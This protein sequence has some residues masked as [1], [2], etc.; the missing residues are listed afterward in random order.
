M[1]PSSLIRAIGLDRLAARLG[2]GL[3]YVWV[4]TT[5]L[6]PEGPALDRQ[7]PVFYV[8]ETRSLSNLLVLAREARRRGLPPPLAPLRLGGR[9]LPWAVLGLKARQ[10]LFGRPPRVSYI[11]A[12]AALLEAVERDP[13]LEVQL[14]PVSVFW[15]R[16]P[17]RKAS[18]L[19]LLFPDDWPLAGRLRKFLLIL[20][21][22][23]N[24][25]VEFSP[26]LRLRRYREEIEPGEHAVRKLA[27]VLGVHFRL[28]RQAVLGPELPGRRAVIEVLVNASNVRRAIRE[29][30][31]DSEFSEAQLTV[32]ARRYAEEIA[33]GFSYPL[34]LVLR[35]ALH[36]VWH[37]L[38]DGIALNHFDSVREALP[39]NQ[40]IYVPCHRSHIDY[41]LILYLLYSQGLALP[42]V[43]AGINLNA[44]GIGFFVR[45]G[46]AFF[47]RRTFKGN[48]L[49]ATVLD[50]YMSLHLARGV[51]LKYFIEGG[52]SRSGYLLTPKMGLLDMTV[53][54]FFRYPY[55]PVVFVPI[56][57]GYER[58]VE[59]ES[60]LAELRG[61]KKRRESL[62]GLIRSLGFLRRYH[63]KVYLNVGEPLDLA[64]LLAA[65]RR[66]WR[67]ETRD[68][69]DRP[70][71]L[72]PLVERLARE[73][74]T[75]VNEA[76]A[77][78]PMNLLALV[79]LGAPRCAMA[80]PALLAQLDL[81]RRLL[82]R[83]P[84]HPRT[85][86]TEMD[87]R[88]IL[89][90]A[91][92]LVDLHVRQDELGRIVYLE[93]RAGVLVS[94]FR[95]NS[96]HLLALPALL[97]R[98]FRHVP[99]G[100]DTAQLVAWL[101]LLY[102]G[103]RDELFLHWDEA[104]LPAEVPRQLAGLADLGLLLQRDGRWY[105]APGEAGLRLALLGRNVATT[106]ERLAVVAL[107]LLGAAPGE[108]DETTLL[109]RYRRF[110][111]R[112]ELLHELSLAGADERIP[113]PQLL[114]SLV[115][116]GWLW[117]D[118]DGRLG[119]EPA[120]LHA[121][122]GLERLL[123]WVLRGELVAAPASGLTVGAE[124]GLVS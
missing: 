29:E 16:S 92:R 66:D 50:E 117:R 45:R 22:G 8:L 96:L 99:D 42:R 48:R 97:A 110:R 73:I 108:L 34:I 18:G 113:L 56:Y 13:A 68:L 14:Q 25:W 10:R 115:N 76:A 112:V 65:H 7:Q 111:T 83:L 90:H 61:E 15:G 72:P 100:L 11:P 80:E 9:L 46:G 75:R 3:L 26:P 87:P 55:R 59:G 79:L 36:W 93:T 63:G 120:C 114:D 122:L 40:V 74:Q 107:M 98:C 124:A 118:T 39:G 78:T 2:Q 121:G 37:R 33:A 67:A 123:P 17:E 91:G 88:E 109:G 101:G 60:Y 84:Y 12:L 54:G 62:L 32:T 58:L 82:R 116:A 102:P 95:H 103:L 20:I 19:S 57:I 70:D 30:A 51:P 81:Y 85:T 105:P 44:P 27:L 77:V 21:H 28:R 52:R 106:V 38:Y 41:I 94:Y 71:W 35:R 24:T 6:P 23:R 119:V 5:V 1:T 49:Y 47:L 89:R 64:S 31:V 43:A 69:E 104:D 53:R 4:R 86:V